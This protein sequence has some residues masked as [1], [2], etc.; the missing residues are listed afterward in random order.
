MYLGCMK[1]MR[2]RPI[3]FYETKCAVGKTYQIKC[4]AGQID[5]LPMGT[6]SY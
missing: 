1:K 6:L 4:A 5:K 2:R 3:F